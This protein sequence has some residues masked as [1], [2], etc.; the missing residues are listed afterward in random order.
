MDKAEF[1][2][3]DGLLFGFSLGFSSGFGSGFGSECSLGF[4]HTNVWRIEFFLL[5]AR[6]SR[7][8]AP[9]QVEGV[10]FSFGLG[11]GFCLGC[12]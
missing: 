7:F 10:G 8:A 6:R 11:L 4:R 12:G 3:F 9:D 1:K 2:R 5:N